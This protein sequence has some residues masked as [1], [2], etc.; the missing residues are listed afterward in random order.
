[1]GHK[2]GVGRERGGSGV[3]GRIVS[4][5]DGGGGERKMGG[6]DW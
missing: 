1:M 5:E 2:V 3:K 4:T 6:L